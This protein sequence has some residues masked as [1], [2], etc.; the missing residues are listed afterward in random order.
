VITAITRRIV[1]LKKPAAV[2]AIKITNNR[3]STKVTNG[4]P[5]SFDVDGNNSAQHYS[6]ATGDSSQLTLV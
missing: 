3:R 6:M 1:P 4:L 2:I 5:D